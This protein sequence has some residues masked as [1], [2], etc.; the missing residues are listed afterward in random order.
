MPCGCVLGA[1]HTAEPPTPPIR[2]TPRPPRRPTPA[3]VR[4]SRPDLAAHTA[5]LA[6][7]YRIA[8]A[9]R[10]IIARR[11]ARPRSASL[12]AELLAEIERPPQ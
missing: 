10:R 9:V 8:A 12:L 7:R 6:E 3:P 11:G 1:D 2:P 5:Q 4:T